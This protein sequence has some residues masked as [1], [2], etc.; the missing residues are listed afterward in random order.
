MTFA[1]MQSIQAD[2]K[3][4][5]AKVLVPYIEAALNAAQAP[6]APAGLAALGS[7]AAGAGGGLPALRLGLLHAD[8]A[9][10]RLRRVRH[11][12]N[13]ATPTQDEIDASVATTIY[14][15]WRGRALALFVDAPLQARGLGSVLPAW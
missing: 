13:R 8:R 6:G 7:D 12:G 3:L 2:V 15:L 10:R 14:S 1:E 4:N 9:R 5:D 11:D